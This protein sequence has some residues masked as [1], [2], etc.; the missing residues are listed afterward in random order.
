MYSIISS[1]FSVQQE[2]LQR[3]NCTLTYARATHQN[4]N[5]FRKGIQRY[6]SHVTLHDLYRLQFVKSQ[7]NKHHFMFPLMHRTSSTLL[8]VT[9]IDTLRLVALFYCWIFKELTFETLFKMLFVFMNDQQWKIIQENK[10]KVITDW[11]DLI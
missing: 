10:D 3:L 8:F 11:L 6:T 4:L 7:C 1:M 5:Q 9:L 2:H